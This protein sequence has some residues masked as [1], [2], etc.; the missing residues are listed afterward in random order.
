MKNGMITLRIDGMDEIQRLT[1]EISS[2][3]SKMLGA[4]RRMDDVRLKMTMELNR[5]RS[6]TK[7][8]ES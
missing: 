6:E 1:E 3:Q 2:Y 7:E 5:G 8:D 4:I